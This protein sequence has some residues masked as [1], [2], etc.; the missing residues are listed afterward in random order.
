[1]S[2]CCT[3]DCTCPEH[4]KTG[5]WSAAYGPG[6]CGCL[7]D[8]PG[9]SCTDVHGKALPDRHPTSDNCTCICKG[10]SDEICAANP[11]IMVQYDYPNCRCWCDHLDE[12]GTDTCARDSGGQ[13]YIEE[14]CDCVC[15][16]SFPCPDPKKPKWVVNNKYDCECKCDKEP[17][18]CTGIEPDFNEAECKCQCDLEVANPDQPCQDPT[19]P[20]FNHAKCECECLSFMVKCDE[21]AK[22]DVKKEDCSCFCRKAETGFCEKIVTG[23]GSQAGN[24]Y[25]LNPDDCS[26]KCNADCSAP[27]VKGDGCYCRCPSETIAPT[28]DKATEK[29]DP[30]GCRCVPKDY[31]LS[32]LSEELIP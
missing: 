15:E 5:A 23:T 16:S 27:L 8:Q 29:F 12:D 14:G 7:Y 11:G 9:S 17:A 32:F 1:M 31:V 6:C 18:D 26:C 2:R 10:A 13:M 28:C 24:Y 3:N 20:H 21:P 22:P 4:P 19:A 25:V 30:D